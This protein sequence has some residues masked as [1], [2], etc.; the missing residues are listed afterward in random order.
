MLSLDQMTFQQRKQC[1]RQKY[2]LKID[3]DS[4]EKENA[5]T[6]GK[7]LDLLGPKVL[8]GHSH[9]PPLSIALP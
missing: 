9:T 3:I 6:N 4:I 7:I 1:S 5:N 8:A 2:C